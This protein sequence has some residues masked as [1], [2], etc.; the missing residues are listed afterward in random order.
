MQRRKMT[1][2]EKVRREVERDGRRKQETG[3]LRADRVEW[4]KEYC[5]TRDLIMDL[6]FHS[7]L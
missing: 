5:R 2:F 1:G 7:K 4:E 3:E 6:V